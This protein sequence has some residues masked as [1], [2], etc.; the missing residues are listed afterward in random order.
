VRFCTPP[1]SLLI[2]PTAEKT[3]SRKPRAS[4]LGA[5]RKDA[6]QTGLASLELAY[7]LAH[8]GA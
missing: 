5:S 7:F 2:H 4:A 6:T 1:E 8:S 3:S